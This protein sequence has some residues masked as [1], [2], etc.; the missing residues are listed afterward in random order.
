[1]PQEERGGALDIGEGR[2]H[3]GQ[4]Q[5]LLIDVSNNKQTNSIL[6]KVRII[7]TMS[8]NSSSLNNRNRLFLA[9][10]LNSVN[11][12]IFPSVLSN[13]VGSVNTLTSCQYLPLRPARTIQSVRSVR[14]VRPFRSAWSIRSFW[15]ILSYYFKKVVHCAVMCRGGGDELSQFGMISHCCVPCICSAGY[16]D[17]LNYVFVLN[18]AVI[19][20]GGYLPPEI[21]CE[22]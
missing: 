9:S 21:D 1:M 12:R 22:M 10:P 7:E 15:S 17:I 11:V 18:V 8:L 3:G 14:A 6:K 20:D 16:I 2:K 13:S 4:T 19:L 5:S